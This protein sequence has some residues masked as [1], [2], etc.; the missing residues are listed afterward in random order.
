MNN[1]LRRGTGDVCP[2]TKPGSILVLNA[3]LEPSGGTEFTGG[4]LCGNGKIDGTEACDSGDLAG[5]TC[6]DL[7]FSGGSLRC[8]PNCT[9]DTSYCTAQPACGNGLPDPGLACKNFLFTPPVTCAKF[10]FTAG[11][12]GKITCDPNCGLNSSQC[13]NSFEI[14]TGEPTFLAYEQHRAFLSNEFTVF[15]ALGNLKANTADNVGLSNHGLW[16]FVRH[17]I[18]DQWQIDFAVPGNE[19]MGG[20][21]DDISFLKTVHLTFSGSALSAIDGGSVDTPIKL[22]LGGAKTGSF[23]P[24]LVGGAVAPPIELEVRLKGITQETWLEPWGT[25]GGNS[26]KPGTGVFA[27]EPGTPGEMQVG[28]CG[29]DDYCKK[30]WNHTTQRFETTNQTLSQ[31]KVTSDWDVLMATMKAR[32]VVIT[33][34]PSGF[35]D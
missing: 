1:D 17:L 9:Y 14:V 21:K 23:V 11:P 31:S 20:P 33:L 6:T 2:V 8:Y 15:D 24:S 22:E 34:P 26:F 32:G 19:Y 4:V 27:G 13:A 29:N 10:G 35:P 3:K 12:T 18:K 7:G 30:A 25:A 16:V 5:K 28:S